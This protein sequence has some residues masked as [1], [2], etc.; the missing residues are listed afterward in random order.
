MNGTDFV[1][2][3]SALQGSFF[4]SKYIDPLYL[5]TKGYIFVQNL[6]SF[7]FSISKDA[8]N[9]FYLVL[10]LMASFFIFLISYCLIRIFEIRKKEH[11]HVD[12]EIAEY[13]HHQAERERK[14]E[15]DVG[16]S[17]NPRWKETLTYLFSENPGDWKLAII[18][19]DSML[20]GLLDQLGFKGESLG[21]KLKSAGLDNFRN[22][23]AAWEVHNIRNRIAHEGLAYQISHHEAKRVIAIYENIFRDFGYI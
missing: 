21:E 18:E 12:H 6:L 7:S 10:F 16:G 5:F 22:L 3:N 9:M 20:E 4:G 8:V 13:A 14:K 19:A 15:Q 2:N 17:H 23:S 1:N 11:H